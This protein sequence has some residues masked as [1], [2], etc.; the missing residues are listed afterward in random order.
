M[1]ANNIAVR[2]SNKSLGVFKVIGKYNQFL[3]GG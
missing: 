2:I 1:A 3:A